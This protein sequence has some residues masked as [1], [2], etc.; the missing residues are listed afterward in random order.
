[1]FCPLSKTLESR[2]TLP[3]LRAHIQEQHVS[4]YNLR[5]YNKLEILHVKTTTYNY[6]DCDH[7]D[8][9]LLMPGIT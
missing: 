1:M 5:G 7:L 6:M 4:D 8:T 9:L 3:Y 2:Y